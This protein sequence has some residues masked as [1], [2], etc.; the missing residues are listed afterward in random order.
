MLLPA[1]QDLQLPCCITS[2][3]VLTLEGGTL[4]N[5]FLHAEAE[6]EGRH[7]GGSH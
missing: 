2:W 4:T 7:L 6:Q 3:R 5:I 1:Q